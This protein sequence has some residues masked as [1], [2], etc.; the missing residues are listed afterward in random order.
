M[1]FLHQLSGSGDFM[2]HGSCDLRNHG[3]VW[4]HII[5][6]ALIQRKKLRLQGT[7]A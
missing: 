6:E 4:L 1:D 3:E 2:P 7:K 5:S